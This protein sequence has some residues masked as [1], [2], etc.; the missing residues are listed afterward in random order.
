MTESPEKSLIQEQGRRICNRL[1]DADVQHETGEM[2]DTYQTTPVKYQKWSE[3][4]PVAMTE[5]ER[6][7]R[8]VYDSAQAQAAL[9][10]G[11]A[12]IADSYG[13][14]INR[15]YELLENLNIIL[16]VSSV[17]EIMEQLRLIENPT[18]NQNRDIIELNFLFVQ[19]Q[20]AGISD[21][22]TIAGVKAYMDA[23]K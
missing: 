3:S 23:Q 6:A 10:A 18:G 9:D 16:P 2:M 20:F 17:N 13:T 21:I 4:G 1:E 12:A 11:Y 8:D 7:Q 19:M 15:I 22:E 14:Q 5:E